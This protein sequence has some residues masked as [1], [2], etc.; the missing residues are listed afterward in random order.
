MLWRSQTRYAPM[1]SL[2]IVSCL[3][4]HVGLKAISGMQAQ[5]NPTQ[6][7]FPTLP[8]VPH[9]LISRGIALAAN[10]RG[11]ATSRRNS[12]FRSRFPLP[13]P[14]SWGQFATLPGKNYRAMGL[15]K[16]EASQ[17][18][19]GLTMIAWL[20]RPRAFVLVVE[21]HRRPSG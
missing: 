17:G 3:L 15:G 12:A 8:T 10:W 2:V 14:V 5:S 21:Q 4:S 16:A 20:W 6:P 7:V 11:A 13:R 19:M 9:L 18:I 1:S